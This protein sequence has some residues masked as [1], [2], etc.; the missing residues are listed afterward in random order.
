M[1]SGR[2][3]GAA[4]LVAAVLAIG[5]PLSAWA[6][7]GRPLHG[8]VVF[9][10]GGL[11]AVLVTIGTLVRLLR[12]R[13]LG[14]GGAA[15]LAVAVVIGALVL[16]GRDSPRINDFT[17]DVEDPPAFHFA[18]RL[19]DNVGR[20]LAY[21]AAFAEVQRGCC[22][23][24]TPLELAL[25]PAEAIERVRRVA[26]ALPRWSV[27]HVDPGAGRVEAVVT[28]R[29]FRFRDDV[30]IRVRP[31]GGGRSRVDMRSKSRD[32]QGDLGAN[33]ARIRAFMAALRTAND[34][35]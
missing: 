24:L 10:L 8:F 2:G 18:A 16:S 7:L 33:A 31:I 4:G 32:G 11:L 25:P 9:A 29:I 6:G 23:D 3:V 17:T 27:T 19:P 34:T 1:R 35:R 26:G 12:G 15:G 28:S 20:D 5:G 13:R 30:V 21:P 14:A 22:A